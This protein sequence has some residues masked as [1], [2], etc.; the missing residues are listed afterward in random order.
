MNKCDYKGFEVAL[1][2][3]NHIDKLNYGAKLIWSYAYGRW[4]KYVGDSENAPDYQR[5]TGKQIGAKYGFLDAGLFRDDADIANSPTVVGVKALPGYIKYVDRNGDGVITAAQD[6]GYVGKSS[7]PTHTGSLNLF[8]DW[9]G[10]DIDILC[11]WGLGNVVALT[12]VYTS[13][14]SEGIQDNTSFTKLFYHGG[15]SPQFLPENSWRPDNLNAE[16]P[17]LEISGPSNNNGY[18]STF[19]YRSGNYMR[20]KTVQLGYNFPKKWMNSIGF[21][22]LRVY[23][24]G[25]NLLTFSKLSKY[26][27]DPESPA[28]NNGYYPQQRT[29]TMGLK[30]TF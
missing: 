28:V 15:N 13:T 4:L 30:L 9:N 29:F 18:S 3:H 6:Q 7:R 22:A 8:A 11:S 23:V 24:E 14:G 16:F 26:N 21:G 5:L 27:I 2:H 20:I 25:Y 17:R 12:G 10:F 1:T 19:W